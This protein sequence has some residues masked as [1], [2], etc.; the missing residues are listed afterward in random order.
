MIEAGKKEDLARQKRVRSARVAEAER[1]SKVKVAGFVP[2]DAGPEIPVAPARGPIRVFEAK[3]LYP[4]G[5]DGY[6]VKPTGHLGR[7]TVQRADVFDRIKRSAAA[8]NKPAPFSPGQIAMG[9]Y[10]RDIVEQ[11]EAGGVKCSSLGDYVQ[12]SGGAAVDI[13]DRRLAAFRRIE[14]LRRRVGVGYALLEVARKKACALPRRPIL[15][16]DIVDLV[17]LGDE[18]FTDV[19][20][21]FGWARKGSA[22]KGLYIR[23]LCAALGAS[24]ERMMGPVQRS[25]ANVARFGVECDPVWQK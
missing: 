5:R 20:R 24:L 3:G 23:V 18:S 14:S 9:R 4:E 2:A 16:M 11:H 19:L 17:C 15:N 21:T 6:V 8:R 7:K 22:A 13:T 10:Y 25:G 12:S 1:I